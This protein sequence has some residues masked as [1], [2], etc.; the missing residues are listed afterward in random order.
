MRK[1]S[2]WASGL[3][4][5]AIPFVFVG[6]V[7][8]FGACIFE[9]VGQ[10]PAHSSAPFQAEAAPPEQVLVVAGA[11]APHDVAQRQSD[12]YAYGDAPHHDAGPSIKQTFAPP[13]QTNSTRPTHHGRVAHKWQG[14]PNKHSAAGSTSPKS[15]LQFGLQVPIVARIVQLFQR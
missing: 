6:A 3:L 12:D 9:A 7:I 15:G 13:D 10:P 2:I 5:S 8:V 11:D 14:S 4:A 1:V